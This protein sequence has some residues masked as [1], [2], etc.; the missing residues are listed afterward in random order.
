MSFKIFIV[1]DDPWYGQLLKHHLSMNPDYEVEVYTSGK[2][3]LSNLYKEPDA[4]CIDFGL[5]D[6]PGNKLLAA[7]RQRNNTLPV[8]VISGQ[9]EISVAVDL[10]KSGARDYII[11][12][13][14]TNNLLWRAIINIRENTTLKKEVEVLKEQLQTKFSFEKTILGQS[15]SIKA[16]FGLLEKAIRTNINVSITGETGTGKEVI[17]KAIHYNSE[18]SK[19]P[20]V[21]VNMSAIPKELIESELFGH[22]KGA[23]TG[24]ITQKIGKF[25][26]ADGGTIL[27]DE[28]G[29]MDINL[30][31]KILRVIQERE[32]VRVGGNKTVKFDARLI[33]ATHKD[34][35]EE[36]RKGTFREDLFFRIVGLPIHL[37]ALRERGQ[38]FYI[39][40]KHFI[41]EF[42]A[43]NKVKPPTIS[44]KAKEKLS[45][46]H[47]P[48]NIREL[49]AVIDLACVMC[50]GSE[51]EDSDIIFHQINQDDFF[52]FAEKTLK[53]YNTDII[54]YYLKKYDNNV[55]K[56]AEKLDIGKSTI[57]NLIKS[58]DITIK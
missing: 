5:P 47:F 37:P 28:I 1:D 17:A 25:E 14:H 38:D 23:F 15:D 51:I 34:L 44:A 52:S 55:V 43:Q 41:S 21:A 3:L 16:I 22:E 30:Q 35:K 54:A 7:I 33:T 58:G 9:E 46:Y 40:A 45:H 57:Y 29:E 4:V 31:S 39:L 13:E 24:A 36:V 26:E 8:I 48:G 42:A 27:L 11:K 20:F 12:D 10:L 56:V 2:D 53:E 6:M 32:V 19:K 49:K 50:N 18:R